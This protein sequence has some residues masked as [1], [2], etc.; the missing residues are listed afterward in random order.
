MDEKIQIFFGH[1]DCFEKNYII[2][3]TVFLRGAVSLASFCQKKETAS[4]RE[5]VS[6][7]FMSCFIKLPK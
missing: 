1:K 3:G 6:F 4:T 7:L 5:T 2:F